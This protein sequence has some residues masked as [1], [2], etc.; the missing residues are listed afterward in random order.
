MID[1]GW[2]TGEKEKVRNSLTDW[3]LR[4]FKQMKEYQE[5]GPE[6]LRG[7]VFLQTDTVRVQ[8][9]ECYEQIEEQLIGLLEYTR[10]IK[11]HEV[12]LKSG[13]IKTEIKDGVAMTAEE[14]E[15]TLRREKK[16]AA[17]IPKHILQQLK[18]LS[19]IVGAKDIAKNMIL[20]TEE[21]D[22]Y[23]LKIEKEVQSHGYELLEKGVKGD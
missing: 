3:D 23:Y 19:S 6:T 11:K 17:R 12:E 14:L 13:L 20:T 5:V 2:R 4:L 10:T 9:D 1:K 8:R 7:K 18:V 22:E 15:I 16:T 21:F